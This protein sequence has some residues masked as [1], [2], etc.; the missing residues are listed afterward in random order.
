MNK[1]GRLAMKIILTRHAF[2][3]YCER[4]CP[5]DLDLNGFQE[6]LRNEAGDRLC[7]LEWQGRPAIYLHQAYWRYEY[8]SFK[9]EVTLTTCLGILEMIDLS[10]WSRQKNS[11]NNRY[12]KS[13]A[14]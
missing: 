5:K 9:Q 7:F 14:N 11:R 3:R 1:N 6:D 10:R 4:G 2:E 13:F 12:M 8:N